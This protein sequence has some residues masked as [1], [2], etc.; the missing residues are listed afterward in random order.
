LSAPGRFRAS[1]G[2]CTL[3]L[4]CA[5]A[6][7][8]GC[9]GEIA[10][11]PAIQESAQCLA[12]C[13]DLYEKRVAPLLAT[14]RPKTCNQCHLSGVDLSV[15]VRDNMCETRACLLEL[16]L[17][18]PVNPDD[19]LVL[20]WIARASPDSELITEEVIQEEY[21]AFKSFVHQIATCSGA[22]CAGVH[23][24]ATSEDGGCGRD[25]QPNA[26]TLVPEGTPCDP[27]SMEGAF[28]DSVYVWRDRCFPC[29]FTSQTLADPTA[30]RWIDVTGGCESGSITTLHNIE[31]GGYINVEEPDRSL[32]LLKPLGPDLGGVEHGG[33]DKF[34]GEKDPTYQSFRSF[35]EYYAGCMNGAATP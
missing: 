21:D 32:L 35:A 9:A 16:G 15:F 33:A 11:D 6:A 12:E 7:A 13:G 17:V 25:P 5:A 27:P 8:Q 19:S 29:H 20:T 34:N 23:C 31:Q 2:A 1:L 3:A 4:A 26:A 14:D 30:P 24:P 22:S 18:D 10:I 28:Q